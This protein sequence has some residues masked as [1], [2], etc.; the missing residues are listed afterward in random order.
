MSHI[1]VEK[2]VSSVPAPMDPNT[3]YAVRVGSGFDLYFSD[4]TGSVSH[5]LNQASPFLGA[6]DEQDD[7]GETYFYFGWADVAGSWLVRRTLR[8]ASLQTS[9]SASTNTGFTDLLS[10]WGDRENLSYS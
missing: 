3:I 7:A 8:S 2:S 6:P 9:A 5:Q 10:A 1:K 4:L